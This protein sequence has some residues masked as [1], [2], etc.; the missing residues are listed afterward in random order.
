[1]NWRIICGGV[2][3]P[4]HAPFIRHSIP[5]YGKKLDI[6]PFVYLVK[7]DRPGL[8]KLPA[9]PTTCRATTVFSPTLMPTCILV[10]MRR[11]SRVPIRSLFIAQSP[12]FR[13]NLAYTSLCLFTLVA[14]AFFPAITVKRPAIL[15]CPSLEWDF[16]IHRVISSSASPVMARKRPCTTNSIFRRHR[17]FLP[18]TLMVTK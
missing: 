11:G 1:M 16:C 9:R 13:R 15:V 5:I 4:K 18:V 7:Y 17:L 6:I 10:Q 12:I 3:I 8:K 2:G 14:W